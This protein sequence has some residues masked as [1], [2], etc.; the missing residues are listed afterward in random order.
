MQKQNTRIIP[1][2]Q[3]TQE[4]LWKSI[5]TCLSLGICFYGFKTATYSIS[6]QSATEMP[7]IKNADK[8]ITIT[9][10]VYN[11]DIEFKAA[12]KEAIGEES[13]RDNASTLLQKAANLNGI[14]ILFGIFLIRLKI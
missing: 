14:L 3:F 1:I 11:S 13:A 7:E 2:K 10:K 8:L 12:L 9:G 6:E 5:Y 4:L